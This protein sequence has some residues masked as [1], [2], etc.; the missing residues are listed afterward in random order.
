MN[1]PRPVPEHGRGRSF[2][3]GLRVYLVILVCA[4]VPFGVVFGLLSASSS[5]GLAS[6]A[7][8][9]F[10]MSAILGTVAVVGHRGRGGTF[11]PRQELTVRLEADVDRVRELAL[12][13]L[14]ELPAHGVR[15]DGPSRVESR[16]R[17]SWRSWGE[18]LTVE[19]H[20][21]GSA[22][23]VVIRSRPNVSMTVVDYGKGR[24]NVEAIAQ[25]LQS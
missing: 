25:R 1:A 18:E 15:V 19:L 20:P 7:L 3:R 23:D 22:T 4:G 14:Q 21:V 9:G 11:S 17:M 13:A 12:G 16:T 6:G 8:F 5:I 2:L 10:F 24:E